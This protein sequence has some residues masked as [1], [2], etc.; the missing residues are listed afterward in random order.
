MALIAPSLSKSKTS[1]IVE[2]TALPSIIVA[3]QVP[4]SRESFDFKVRLGPSSYLQPLKLKITTAL[5]T[6]A[7]GV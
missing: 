7:K 4:A 6:E 3:V 1:V 5:R 2:S